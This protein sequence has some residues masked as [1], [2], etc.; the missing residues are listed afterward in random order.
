M[1]S[2]FATRSDPSEGGRVALLASLAGEGPPPGNGDFGVGAGDVS[3]ITRIV[4][5]TRTA[6]VAPAAGRG[7]AGDD[8]AATAT[9]LAGK[10][11][12]LDA[13]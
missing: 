4:G 6:R 3:E 5:S 12:A 8:A 2:A 9:E 1:L 11:A 10:C 13:G 7:V